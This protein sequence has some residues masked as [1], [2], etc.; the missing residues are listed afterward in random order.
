MHGHPIKKIVF[1]IGLTV[2]P[3]V[4]LFVFLQISSHG[5]AGYEQAKYLLIL[6]LPLVIYI[7]FR[8]LFK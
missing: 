1:W 8:D 6:I 3:A 5:I 4:L 2:L 7:A